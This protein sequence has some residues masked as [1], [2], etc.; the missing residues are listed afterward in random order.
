MSRY[1]AVVNVSWKFENEGSE[2]DCVELIKKNLDQIIQKKSGPNFESFSTQISVVKLKEKKHLVHLGTFS[3]EEVFPFISNEETRKDY[4]VGD[5]IYSVKMRSD[6]YLLFKNN[7]NCVACN[8]EGTQLIL[9]LSSDGSAHFNLY[10]IEDECLVLM[11]KDH[12]LARS[13]GGPNHLDNYRTMCQTCNNIRGNYDLSLDQIRELRVLFKEN[14][15][16]L[17][18]K[19]LWAKISILRKEYQEKS[20]KYEG[21]IS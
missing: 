10:G 7:P 16:N 18:R 20:N 4:Q 19:D 15:D 12:E 6:R 1:K 17:S 8:L 13:H 14:K 5:K 2:Y 3:K 11:T 21:E 9:D